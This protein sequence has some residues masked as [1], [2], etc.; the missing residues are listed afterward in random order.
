MNNYMVEEHCLDRRSV[1]A[2][3]C[4]GETRANAD[5]S[6]ARQVR[7]LSAV[8]SRFPERGQSTQGKSRPKV[9]PKGVAD[10]KQVNIPAPLLW[11]EAGAQ[12][13][14]ESWVLDIPSLR[15]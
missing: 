10:G 2:R 11:S 9:R 12:K 1:S 8:N 7:T 5:M 6:S 4:G 13:D 3:I 15:V 14:N